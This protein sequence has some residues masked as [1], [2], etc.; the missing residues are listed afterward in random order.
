MEPA[1]RVAC[2]ALVYREFEAGSLAKGTSLLKRMAVHD[3]TEMDMMI[4][5]LMTKTEE[6]A[7]VMVEL[8]DFDPMRYEALLHVWPPG[9]NREPPPEEGFDPARFTPERWDEVEDAMRDL[10]STGVTHSPSFV[11][12]I[13]E[14]AY[15]AAPAGL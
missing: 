7:E 2:L 8:A 6:L 15:A 1:E 13:F 3:L 14:E 11:N 10:Y 9:P 4:A 12:A 5:G